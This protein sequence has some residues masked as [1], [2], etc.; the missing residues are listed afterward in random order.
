MKL[1]EKITSPEKIKDLSVEQLSGLAE[2]IR[3]SIISSVSKTGGHLATNLG[4]VELTIALH[5]VLDISRDKLVWDVSNQTYSHKIL[6]GR[7]DKMDTIRQ[8]KGLAGFAKREESKYDHFGAGHASTSISAA[9]G[10]AVARDNA[11]D[12]YKVVAIIGDGAMTGGLAFEGLNNAGSLKNDLTVI[13]NDNSWSISKNV[14]AMSKYLTNMLTDE[15]FNKLRD[16]IWEMTGRFKRRDKIRS[17]I[18]HIE[19]SVRG[20]IV[21]GMLFQ[22][23]G[24]RYFGPI[25]GHD[26]PLLIRTLGNLKNI[27]GPKMLHVVTT[28]GKGYKPAEGNP[29]KYHGVSSFDKITGQMDKKASTLPSYTEVFGN[30]M[31]ELAAK[32][33]NVIAITAAMAPGTGLVKFSE[34]F[35]KRFFDVGI[36][37]GHAGTFA[38]GIS[39]GGGKPYL[40]IYST[41]MQRAFDMVMHDMALQKLP[42]VLCMDRGGLVGSDGPTHHGVY[43][44]S[45]ISTLPDIVMAVP[46]DGNELRSML[47]YTVD[48]EIKIPIAIRYPRDTIPTEMKSEIEPIDWGCWEQLTAEGD[49]TV[50]AVGTMVTTALNIKNT[51]KEKGINISVVN[52]RFVKPFD[53][54]FL[55]KVMKKSKAVV[56]IEENALIGGFG[57]AVA[58][59]LLTNKY[60]GSFTALGIPDRYITHGTRAELLREIELDEKGVSNAIIALSESLESGNGFYRKLK[61]FSNNKHQDFQKEKEKETDIVSEKDLK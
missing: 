6:T 8:Y 2:E 48:N 30:S 10:M 25:N 14:G 20:V 53:E 46:K 59:Y 28:K 22:K 3:Q 9:L 45:F 39:A 31:I 1:L 16:E 52:A 36:A 18:Q 56:T 19:Q 43:D 35:P 15:K 7:R 34:E 49:I 11:D 57:Q 5:Y 51:L 58:A 4:S 54:Q 13:L 26:L 37:E 29:T 47:H 50:L 12:D 55:N 61:I 27:S 24:F 60:Q 17:A 44:L 38:A 41:F 32:D 33:D 42:V 40:T 21:P 23:L